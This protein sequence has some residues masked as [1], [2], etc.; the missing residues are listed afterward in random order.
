V[1]AVDDSVLRMANQIAANFSYLPPGEAA[2]ATADH[3]RSFWTPSM[4]RHLL[5]QVA[6][7]GGGLTEV[8]LEAARLL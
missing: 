5:E 1:T 3:L 2:A 8:A 6:A 4:R 7:G